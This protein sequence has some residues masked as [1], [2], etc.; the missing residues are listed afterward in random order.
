MP[1][2]LQSQRLPKKILETIDGDPLIV[3]SITEVLKAKLKTQALIAAVDSEEVAKVLKKHFPEDSDLKVI[4]TSPDCPSGT[5]RVFEAVKIF[6]NDSKANED[7]RII[8]IQGD[9]PFAEAIALNNFFEVVENKT[10]E[11]Y[12]TVAIPWPSNADYNAP[13]KVKCLLDTHSHAIYFSRLGIPFSQPHSK[14]E[15]TKGFLH[16]GLYAYSFEFLEAFC[17]LKPSFLERS[18]SLE[19]LRAIENGMPLY[20]HVDAN[21]NPDNFRGI[22]TSEDLQWARNRIKE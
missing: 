15:L 1:F 17:A 18:E 12:L 3:K 14:D 4:T 2:R 16:L 20:V 6:L 19:Q 21:I 11:N 22:D 10:S 13:S 9:M 8:N 7:L 5:D